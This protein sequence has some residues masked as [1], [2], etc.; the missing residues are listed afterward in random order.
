MEGYIESNYSQV[1]E[2]IVPTSANYK[3]Y[4]DLYPF[5]VGAS[6]AEEHAQLRDQLAM[7][8]P[9]LDSFQT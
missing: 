1:F 7:C 2:G 8:P 3:A 5:L 4:G 6:T 9:S